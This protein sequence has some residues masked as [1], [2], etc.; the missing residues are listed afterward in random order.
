MGP[1]AL[2]RR[3]CRPDGRVIVLDTS[4]I[5]ALVDRRDPH[6]E[7][8][9][10]VLE[11]ERGPLLVPAAI[12]AEV[13]YL[14]EHRLG[15]PVL[16]L[17]LEDVEVGAYT[18]DYGDTDIARIRQLTA[19]YADLPLGLADAAVVACAERSGGRVLT[20]DRRDFDVVA[21]E[22]VLTALP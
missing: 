21:G 10:G 7:A 6:H 3:G 22:V 8:T 13:G 16:D 17:F 20:L 15:Q 18:L 12:L 1:G 14:L 5:L 2:G 19:R 9:V 11:S 4:A